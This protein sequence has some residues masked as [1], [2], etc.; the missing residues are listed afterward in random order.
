VA[1][2]TTS[3]NRAARPDHVEQMAGTLTASG[4]P[5]MPARVLMALM[6]SDQGAMTGQELRDALGISASAVSGAVHYLQTLH[7]VRR[8]ALPGT[9]R[10]RYELPDDPWYVATA[11]VGSV[12]AALIRQSE[13]WLRDFDD[14]D[15]PAARRVAEMTEFFRM[16]RE[17]MPQLLAEWKARSTTSRR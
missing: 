15:S 3:D 11:D 2:R 8:V 1:R 5:R 6:A 13:A 10:E 7:L 16:M 17:R 4:F 9:R 12:Y 14:P